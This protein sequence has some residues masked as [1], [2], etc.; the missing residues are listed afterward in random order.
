MEYYDDFYDGLKDNR[1][2]LYRQIDTVAIL[3]KLLAT[4][5]SEI[6]NLKN[7]KMN[8]V[9]EDT[10]KTKEYLTKIINKLNEYSDKIQE[11]IKVKEGYPIYQL[12]DIE[13]ISLIKTLSSMDY[14]INTVNNNLNKELKTIKKLVNESIQNS[15]KEGDYSS[16]IVL[17]ELL[18]ITNKALLYLPL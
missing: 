14:K 7:Y 9:G 13:S 18:S 4:I 12:N 11:I 15:Y 1:N 17:S 6:T 10:V 3:N 16:I 8:L 2:I 5:F